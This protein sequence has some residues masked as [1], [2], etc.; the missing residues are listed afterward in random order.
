M[1]RG[2]LSCRDTGKT[3]D[4]DDLEKTSKFGPTRAGSAGPAV[5]AQ[6]NCQTW[7]T[8]MRCASTNPYI[9]LKRSFATVFN[10]L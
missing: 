6:P 5:L 1:S 3:R 9:H 4:E 10:R 2:H 7:E 8:L